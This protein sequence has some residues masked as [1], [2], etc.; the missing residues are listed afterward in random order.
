[1][2]DRKIG[3]RFPFSFLCDVQTG[4]GAQLPLKWASGPISLG[5][6]LQVREPHHSPPS[7]DDVKKGGAIPPLPHTSSCYGKER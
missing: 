6:K 7:S 2:D 4:S 1:M 5:A 3:V